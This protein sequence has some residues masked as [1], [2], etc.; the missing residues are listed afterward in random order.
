[1]FN[2]D[3]A[4]TMVLG[5]DV[6]TPRPAKP[7]ERF[8]SVRKIHPEY[9]RRFEIKQLIYSTQCVEILIKFDIVC[10]LEFWLADNECSAP[11]GAAELDSKNTRDLDQ[12]APKWHVVSRNKPNQCQ[13]RGRQVPSRATAPP[14]EPCHVFSGSLFLRDFL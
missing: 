14:R 6:G 4:E 7:M 1:M 9:H 13:P 5:V 8:S 2:G 10:T 12:P 11:S 3:I